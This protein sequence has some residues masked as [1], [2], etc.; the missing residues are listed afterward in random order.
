MNKVDPREVLLSLKE[1]AGKRT[2]KSLDILSSVLEK[3]S[4]QNMQDFSIVTIGKL[5]EQAGGPSTQTI[6]NKTGAHYQTLI[7][8]WAAWNDKTI[9]KPVRNL[10]GNSQT[11]DTEIL[12]NISDPVLRA[13]VGTIL[14]DRNRYRS[15]L[16]TLKQHANV[17]I[18]TRKSAE[19]MSGEV[20]FKLNEMEIVALKESVSDEFFSQMNWIITQ[21]G[22]VKSHVGVQIYRHGYV[23]AIKKIIENCSIVSQ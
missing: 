6:R 10:S 1:N 15:Q 8:T 19:V 9:K 20:L 5:S 14:A 3:H 18:D 4:S 11:E 7:S 17:T 13:L 2:A 22:Q 12:K 23:N 21:A 16:N